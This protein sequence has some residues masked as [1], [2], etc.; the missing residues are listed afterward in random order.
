MIFPIL[1]LVINALT[2]LS[3]L[4]FVVFLSTYQIV[5]QFDNSEKQ[6]FI[7]AKKEKS[8]DSCQVNFITF[9]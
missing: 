4:N 8:R 1:N 5:S 3:S 9:V 6:L 2:E 7:N